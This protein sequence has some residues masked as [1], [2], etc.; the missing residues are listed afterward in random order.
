[1]LSLL[2]QS[3]DKCFQYVL[4]GLPPR[5]SL[6]QWL[7]PAGVWLVEVSPGG[8]KRTWFDTFDWRLYKR[9]LLLELDQGAD[10]WQL[11]LRDRGLESDCIGQSIDHMPAF[12]VELPAGRLR[13]RLMK[14]CK[15]RALL[16]IVTA[17]CEYLP[18]EARDGNGKTLLRLS[19]LR[20]HRNDGS[21]NRLEC[22]A[23]VIEPLRG[24]VEQTA[25]LCSD[26]QRHLA[27]EKESVDVFDVLCRRHDI[28][29]GLY[30]TKLRLPLA[31]DERA[32]QALGR[33]LA[34]LLSIMEANEAGIHEDLDTEF[35][36]DFR[37]ACRRSRTL[38]TRVRDVLPEQE[39]DHAR[40]VFAWL[41]EITGPCRDMDVFLLDLDDLAESAGVGSE[42]DSLGDL[43]RVLG[44]ER[45]QARA[46]L[47]RGLRSRRYERF[48]ADWHGVL[49]R[50]AGGGSEATAAA[51]PVRTVADRCI[52]KAYRKILRDGERL[53]PALDTVALHDLR[54][55]G[56]KLRYLLEAFQTLYPAEE[57][58][59]VIATLKKLQDNM[60]AIV[61]AAVQSETLQHVRNDRRGELDREE[62][63]LF[64][65]QLIDYCDQRHDRMLGA[66]R[67]TFAEFARKKN[68]KRC[69]S[70]FKPR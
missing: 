10:H 7:T 56:K 51:E 1:M 35:L 53:D 20:L 3:C 30:E 48:K 54:K 33:I 63:V 43:R 68:R 25:T 40:T 24:Y 13:T 65:Q 62:T 66:F 12:P 64:I 31:A 5:Q 23:L 16:P 57:I 22:E 28:H 58:R 4:D 21:R 8:F 6:Q 59:E 34:Y 42:R 15:L 11:R 29:P 14:L 39:R 18:A 9:D 26:L 55:L 19:G 32:D 52:W 60:G 67:E 70:L 41:S 37:I 44:C 49:D 17:Y 47:L 36:H 2:S 38:V 46:R 50:A 45:R 69:K 27:A 61:D